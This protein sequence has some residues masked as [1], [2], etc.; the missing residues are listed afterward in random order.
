MNETPLKSLRA[1]IRAAPESGIV[2]VVNYGRERQGLIPLWAGEGDLPTPRF[3]YDSAV[4]S[5][6]NGETFYTYQRGIPEL[7]EA[8][9]AYHSRIYNM[10]LKPDRFFVTGAGMQAV[11]IALQSVAGVGDE[12][13]LPD[14]GWPNFDAAIQVA[15]ATPIP[16]ALEKRNGKWV[17]DI[18]P[19]IAACTEKTRAI[20]VNSPGNPTGVVLT[21]EQILHLR[22]FCR[23]KGIWIISD[24]VYGRFFYDGG[25]APSFLQV[26]DDED[27]LL[28]VNTFSKNWA[29]TGW[30]VG[31]IVGPS[32][33]G[34][35][36]ENMVQ[37]STSGV[38]QFSQR[39]CITALETGED[40]LVDSV[41][42]ARASRDMVCEALASCARVSLAPP[43]GA[44]YL[45]FAVD[46]V[47]DSRA[48]ALHLID[49]A[50]VG[51][52]PGIAFGAKGE[53]HF[54]LCFAGS[55]DRLSQAMERLVP[56]LS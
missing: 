7:R 55:Q 50:N 29:M 22:D 1:N 49:E 44:F 33:L 13:I 56:A 48:F 16:V 27:L 24:E 26:C 15:G 21:R 37:Y 2:E 10:D 8:L 53:R 40:F 18:E 3:I 31:W 9:A 30:R 46:G 25:V 4:Q 11:Q 39:A 35:V 23:E 41:A 42:K 6:E 47:D 36:M 54:R 32:S 17:Y 34:Q 20:C 5:L 52:A 28:V 14:P 38:P 19:I 51:L 45:F 43:E 12:V